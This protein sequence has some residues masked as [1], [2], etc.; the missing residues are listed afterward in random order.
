[1][2]LLLAPVVQGFLLAFFAAAIN[3]T[4]RQTR[5]AVCTINQSILPRCLWLPQSIL[6]PKTAPV[7]LPNNSMTYLILIKFL[8]H[9]KTILKNSFELLNPFSSFQRN[10]LATLIKYDRNFFFK[11]SK[12]KKNHFSSSTT[13]CSFHYSFVSGKKQGQ[14]CKYFNTC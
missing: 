4:K 1:M 12:K 8:A 13:D 11:I 3:S 7:L 2:C 10:F 14:S 9:F 5:Q 6:T